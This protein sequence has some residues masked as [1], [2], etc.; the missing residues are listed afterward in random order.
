MS[1]CHRNGQGGV[2]CIG[3]LTSDSFCSRQTR[4]TAGKEGWK[5]RRFFLFGHGSTNCR[6]NTLSLFP[7]TLPFLARG[8]LGPS[9]FSSVYDPLLQFPLS[10]YPSAL[11]SFNLHAANAPRI[12]SRPRHL[13][14][15]PP[16]P[17][18]SFQLLSRRVS[19]EMLLEGIRRGAHGSSPVVA[20]H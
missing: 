8:T 1:P 11:F 3:G 15:S 2:F 10:T 19:E 17:S 5:I 18:T 6:Y 16:P 7:L 12:S 13:R 9:L 14:S 20:L 4:Q